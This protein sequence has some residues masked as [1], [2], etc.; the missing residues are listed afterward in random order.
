[1][2]GSKSCKKCLH[3]KPLYAFLIDRRCPD[4]RTARCHQCIQ[5]AKERRALQQIDRPGVEQVR[6]RQTLDLAIKYKLA[7]VPDFDIKQCRTCLRVC[8]VWHFYSQ[9]QNAD[10]LETRCDDCQRGYET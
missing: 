10:G 9:V 6:R 2:E 8:G 5:A 3:K 7:N 1:M 4:G